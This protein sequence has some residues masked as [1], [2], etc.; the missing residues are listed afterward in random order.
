RGGEGNRPDDKRG[1]IFYTAWSIRVREDDPA[2]DS[3]GV[4]PP[5]EGP[6]FYRGYGYYG[7]ETGEAEYGN[8]V[9]E[10]CAVSE[11]DRPGQYRLRP[12]NPQKTEKRNSGAVCLLH[13]TDRSSGTGGP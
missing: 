9:P 2:E 5:L 8:R 11:Y 6:G 13:G 12:E 10:L 7:L 3:G 4:Y 1:R